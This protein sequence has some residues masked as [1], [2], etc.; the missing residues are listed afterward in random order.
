MKAVTILLIIV[1][2]AT[3]AFSK[4]HS[5]EYKI[6]HVLSWQK[7]SSGETCRE[8]GG[9]FGPRTDCYKREFKLF[10]VQIGELVYELRADTNI[11]TDDPLRALKPDDEFKYR[12]DEKNQIW[13]PAPINKGRYHKPEHEAKYIV[14]QVEKVAS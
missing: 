5:A 9:I 6:G 10:R 7:G 8:N 12:I 2:I 3:P 14:E 13:I 11:D 4:D 1:A